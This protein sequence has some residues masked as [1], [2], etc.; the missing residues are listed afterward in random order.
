MHG[1]PAMAEN[2]S[3]FKYADKNAPK[4]GTLHLSVTGSFDTV[5][6]FTI[7]GKSAQGLNY[8]YDRLMARSWDEPFTLYPLIA[9][10]AEVPDDRSSLT[11]TLNPAARF[12]DGAPITPD[13]V[14]FTFET[15]KDKGRPN[16]R[17]V[18]K[19]VD[20]IDRIG[21][22]GL[23]FNL[24]PEHDRETVMILAM[25]PVLS[26]TY[27]TGKTFDATLIEAPVATGPYKIASI[28]PGRR[29]IL[30]RNKDYWA[31][32]LPAARGQFNFDR[33]VYDYFRDDTV[34]LQAFKKHDLDM[35]V[36]QDPGRWVQTVSGLPK[37]V[38]KEELEHGRVERMW[39]FI[40][41]LRRK[42]FDDLR[43]RK[44]LSLMLD[45]NWINRNI[46]YSLYKPT[47]SFFANSNLAA[48]GAPDQDE[49]VVLMPF[50]AS[51]P[52]E[53]FGPAWQ[54]QASNDPSQLRAL[55]RQADQLLKEAG[56]V[57]KNGSRVNSK[58]GKPFT[59][60]IILANATDEKIALSFKHSLA[61]LGIAV[62]LRTLDSAAFNDRMLGYE[63]DMTVNFWQNSLSPG[64]EQM[65]Y[66]GC[67]SA[68][69]QG[70]FNYSGICNPAIETIARNIP[71]VETREE[72]VAN[73]HA[74]DR[75]LTHEHIA[76]PLFYS[77]RD[78]VA[79][80]DNIAHPP[81]RAL[82]GNIMENWYSNKD[83]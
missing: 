20:T 36:E 62:S 80:W 9:E 6:P 47:N 28:E 5:N 10:R 66:W 60:E 73:V 49:L 72:L 54:P 79:S 41:N 52:R 69:N 31:A 25:M 8:V 44:A 19:L 56:F 22:R 34:A 26:K 18:Y 43:V 15:L 39:G 16:M 3:A 13:D 4:G 35:R 27:W 7:K 12:Q 37:N 21:E 45:Y 74:L 23:R 38:R 24:K 58:T 11:I 63:Y 48:S 53:V 55:Q 68:K 50:Q 30:E 75:I 78:F 71:R 82:Y 57:I 17:Q 76:I 65:Q 64:T 61:R 67:A 33:I 59:F 51:L 46:F 29:I 2:F 83:N 81:A 40:F 32:N 70:S 42:P 1:D 77:G 14:L